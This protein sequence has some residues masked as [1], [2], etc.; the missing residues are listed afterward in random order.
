KV[1]ER[2][3]LADLQRQYSWVQGYVKQVEG[4]QAGAGPMSTSPTQPQGVPEGLAEP[5]LADPTQ[6]AAEG[7][8]GPRQPGSMPLI[9]KFI[10]VV[11]YHTGTAYH[12]GSRKNNH[13][14]NSFK[15]GGSSN[16]KDPR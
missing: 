13:L 5:G 4:I 3:R 10:S 14:W 1:E 16:Y 7:L 15:L 11:N 6:G 9:Q 2:M 12:V 8:V